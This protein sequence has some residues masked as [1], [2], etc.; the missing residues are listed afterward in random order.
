MQLVITSFALIY[1]LLPWRGVCEI[2]SDL[3]AVGLDVAMKTLLFI[4]IPAQMF[5]LQWHFWLIKFLQRLALFT[6]AAITLKCCLRHKHAHEGCFR[7][8]FLW[9]HLKR[10]I[11]IR[12]LL[13]IAFDPVHWHLNY[14]LLKLITNTQKELA[15]QPPYVCLCEYSKRPAPWQRLVLQY[16]EQQSNRMLTRLKFTW[17]IFRNTSTRLPI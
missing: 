13:A 11:K 2:L 9:C 3:D 6:A 5:L 15:Q 12:L 1:I 14:C 7:R 10:K 16:A 17:E 8:S 4:K